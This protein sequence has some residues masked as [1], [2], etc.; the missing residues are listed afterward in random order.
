MW[1]PN[2]ARQQLLH[3][4]IKLGVRMPIADFHPHESIESRVIPLLHV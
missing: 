2:H 1:S 4:P 3:A